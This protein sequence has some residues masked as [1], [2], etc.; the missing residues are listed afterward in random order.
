MDG[1]RR[2]AREQNR[3]LSRVVNELL[4]EGLQRRRRAPPRGLRQ[5]S[6]AMGVPRVNLADRDA[7]EAAMER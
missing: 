7:L 6:F 4:T 5:P 3:E 2:L 1:V